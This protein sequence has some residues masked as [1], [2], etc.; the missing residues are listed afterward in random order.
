M[1]RE[2]SLNEAID[3]ALFAM[4]SSDDGSDN[5][6]VA[7][8]MILFD[9]IIKNPQEILSL[10]D[11]LKLS[12]ISS[13]MV[14]S[15][16]P[17]KFSTYN[18]YNTGEVA[19]AIGFYTFMKQIQNGS[20]PASFLPA[21]IVLIHDG[22]EYMAHL[23]EK[24]VLHRKSLD[25]NPYNVF[26]IMAYNDA[27]CK[28]YAI[29]KG[30]ELLIHGLYKNSGLYYGNID[31]WRLELEAE[32]KQIEQFIGMDFHLY[33]IKLYQIIEDNLKSK[34]PYNFNS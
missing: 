21:F 6:T 22:R 10:R 34:E 23:I 16:F 14:S 7:S 3:K 28:K 11:N 30:I 13:A 5:E 24:T 26:E 32:K 18:S 29:T 31:N 9:A 27:E 33:A 2:F 20:L 15:G 25:I 12:L 4:K 19:C 1:N 8:F 17:L